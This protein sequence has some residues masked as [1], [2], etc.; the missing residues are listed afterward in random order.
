M[1]DLTVARE[2]LPRPG[3]ERSARSIARAPTAQ[4]TTRSARRARASH[5]DPAPPVGALTVAAAAD[6]RDRQG[7]LASNARHPDHGRADVARSPTTEVDGAVRASSAARSARRSASST[8]RTGWRRSSQI[9]RP[10][11]GPARRPV[12]GDLRRSPRSTTTTIIAMMVGRDVWTAYFRKPRAR[13][14]AATPVAARCGACARTAACSSDVSLRASARGE[15]L[16]LAG[17]V[18]CGPHRARRAPSSAPTRSTRRDRRRSA[19]SR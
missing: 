10:R 15:I 18:G 17:L 6:G 4:A 14:D 2:H 8:S 3:A 16:G 13:S 19:A 11:H 12:V 7:A 5:L 1:P 9:A